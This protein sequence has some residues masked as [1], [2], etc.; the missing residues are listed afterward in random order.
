MFRS[1]KVFSVR[2]AIRTLILISGALSAALLT[3]PA[4]AINITLAFNAGANQ[5]PAFDL[6][7]TG[8][9][10]L[11]EH[12][13]AFYQDVFEDAHNITIN[14]WYEDLADSTLGLH[15]LVTEGGVPNRE[16]Q[17]NIRIDTR[18]GTGGALR[19][20]FIDPTPDNDSEFNMQQTLWRDISATQQADFYN[21]IGL[22]V[23]AT[24]ETGYTGVANSG[25]PADGLADML[26]VVMHEVGHALGMASAN[27]STVAQTL[28]SDYDFDSNFIFGQTLAAEVADGANIAH[29]DNTRALMTPSI[30][31][32]LRRLPSHTDLFSMAS[33]HF[34]T[35]LDIPR[36]EF[37][38]GSDWNTDGNWS[39][40]TVPGSADEVFVRNPGSTVTS[41][42]SAAGFAAD[43]HVSEGGNVNTHGFKLDV[44]GTATIS[45]LDSDI[46]VPTGGELE[47]ST[48]VVQNDAELNVQ[49]GLVDA[50][51]ITLTQGTTATFLQ[52]TSGTIDVQTTLNNNATIRASFGGSLTFTSSGGA[53]W[54][55]DGTNGNGIVQAVLGDLNFASGSVADS[56]DGVMTIGDGTAVRTLTLAQPWS[57][58]S[59]GL[60]ELEGGLT[61][62]ERAILAGGTLTATA[63]VIN[64]N[65]G[66]NH[67]NSPVV[68]GAGLATNTATGA[69]LE[70]N[71]LISVSGGHYNSTGTGTTRFDGTTTYTGGTVNFTGLLQ[72]NGN[73]TVNGNTTIIGD[74]FNF[75]GGGAVAWTLNNDLT[76]TVD[77]IDDVGEVFDGTLNI[78]NSTSALTVN[79]PAPWTLAGTTNIT[80]GTFLTS[81]SIAGQDF[82]ASGII[83]VTDGTRF[84]ATVRLTGTVNLLTNMSRLALNGGDLPDTNRIEG[85][86]VNGPAGSTLRATTASSLTGFGTINSGVDFLNDTVLNADNGILHINGAIVSLGTVGTADS[87]GTLNVSNPW[88]TSSATELRLNGGFVTGAGITNDGTTVGHGQ[89][90]SSSFV[91]NNVVSASGGILTL[92]STTF[93]DLDGGS[94]AGVLNAVD[95]DLRVPGVFA[96]TYIFDGTMNIAS[97]RT[98]RIAATSIANNGAIHFTGGDFQVLGLNQ[99]G[100]LTTAGAVASHLTDLGNGITFRAASQNTINGDLR[101]SGNF[102]IESGAVFAGT[103]RL[104][105]DPAS[106]LRIAN[107]ANVGVGITNGGRFE[108]GASP[109]LALVAAFSQTAGGTYEAE[110]D[111]LFVGTNYDQLQVTGSANLAG[112]L[113]ILINQNGGAYV[114]PAVPGTFNAFTLVTAGSVVGDF[115]QVTYAGVPLVPEFGVSPSGDF[116]ALASCGLYRVV[117]YSG[118]DVQ[119]I[120]YRAIRGDANG[121]G[122]VDGSDFGIWNSNKFTLGTDW[123]TGDFNCD[124]LTDGTDFGIWN[125][126]KFTGIGLPRQEGGDANAYTGQ[127]EFAARSQLVPEPHVT[128]G[129]LLAA[130]ALVRRS[131]RM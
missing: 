33:G 19:S 69:S 97:T 71:G 8:L 122:F 17:A 5:A 94:E 20:W 59:G 128:G 11:F 68:L 102:L 40:D 98:L 70:F 35:A 76:L 81:P 57:M 100:V 87:D 95:G 32:S 93:P 61:T 89:V 1:A 73:A 51:T 115:D 105:V 77:E 15:S 46:F 83:N 108:V 52:G 99:S 6:A 3:L 117:D 64:A 47:A 75:D 107:G 49:G 109:G 80:T 30:S 39:G 36:R 110:I 86:I 78:T 27:N 38:G 28:D 123:S 66:V 79:T 113:E 121:D 131:K 9:T 13:E 106:T 26:S 23:P 118:T 7:A 82:T 16:T 114:D 60:I 43:L 84:D 14:F 18:V 91:N 101:L 111:G 10:S 62:T 130:L 34:Y 120:N 22:S 37:Y 74:I 48:I 126:N 58:G 112:T 90:T 21:N 53:V 25:G 104:F 96:G 55:L 44:A 116:V 63:G 12:A 56:F 72:Q 103:N 124:G 85:G 65:T 50:N 119:L 125:S 92:N 67:V 129:L 45:D 127:F 88:N 31:G 42:L 54:D 41:N 24:F 29:L 2:I 4:Y